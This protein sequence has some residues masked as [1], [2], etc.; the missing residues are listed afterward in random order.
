MNPFPTFQFWLGWALF[1]AFS[2][3]GAAWTLLAL[4]EW[5]MWMLTPYGAAM[6]LAI[7]QPL[8]LRE[9]GHWLWLW[10][11]LTLLGGWL[12]YVYNW[13]FP[14]GLGLLLGLAQWPLLLMIGFRRTFLWPLICGIAWSAGLMLTWVSF[15]TR[16]DQAPN[17]PVSHTSCSLTLGL[18]GLLYGA[19]TGW[20]FALMRPKPGA[21]TGRLFYD[22]ACPFCIKWIRRFAFIVRQGGFE[23]VPLQSDAARRDLGLREGELPTEIKLR[24]AD[25]RLLG[26]VDAYIVLAEAAGWTAPLG[27]LARM[28]GINALAWQVYRWIA[29]NRYCLSETC[30]RPDFV[31]SHHR[32]TAFFELP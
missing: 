23:L 7:G 9:H 2:L 3:G 28:P 11:I 5:K 18:F 17:L 6:A 29:K 12:T 24:L 26:G 30:R 16:M 15:K 22:G 1:H 4:G 27:W 8:L 20:A 32:T 14:V 31:L 10:P 13:Y 25:G 21:T 19:V